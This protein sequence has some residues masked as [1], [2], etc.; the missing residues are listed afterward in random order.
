MCNIHS[1]IENLLLGIM[2][3]ALEKNRSH[4]K[5]ALR[6]ASILEV[7]LPSGERFLYR[8]DYS[9]KRLLLW[10]D[11]SHARLFFTGMFFNCSLQ[12]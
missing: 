5:L 2:V 8:N 7:E 12:E 1:S 6:R 9:R 11:I 4:R 3:L 10:S